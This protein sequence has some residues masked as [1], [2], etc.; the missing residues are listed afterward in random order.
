MLGKVD[1]TNDG[2]ELGFMVGS[3]DRTAD[4]TPEEGTILGVTD[5]DDDSIE[6]TVVGF[7][8]EA[9]DGNILGE[10]LGTMES[11]TDGTKDGLYDSAGV[12]DG[13]DGPKVGDEVIDESSP[14]QVYS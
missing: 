12:A 8:D 5:G 4:G 11:T 13:P 6:G 9:T 3:C 10:V 14:Q 7:T 2:N 1:N